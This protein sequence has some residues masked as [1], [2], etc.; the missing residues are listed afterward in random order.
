MSFQFDWPFSTE[1][2]FYPRVTSLLT[3][4]L[5]KGTKPPIIVDD[6]VVKDL[7]FGTKV[8]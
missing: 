8:C 7:N 3:E 1:D 2:N 6:I 4:A 5:N